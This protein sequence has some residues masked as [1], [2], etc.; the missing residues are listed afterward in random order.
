[1]AD[2][3]VFLMLAIIVVLSALYTRLRKKVGS[4]YLQQ[5]MKQLDDNSYKIISNF[6]LLEN[7]TKIDHVVV[8][9]YGVFIIMREN[10]NGSIYGN[11]T[12][13]EWI[14]QVKKKQ[15]RFSN[16]LLD[17]Q[18]RKADLVN[19]LQLNEKY[20]IPI[21]AFSNKAI[22]AIDPVLL[23]NKKVVHYDEL[24]ANIQLYKTP[25]LS[26]EKVAGIEGKLKALE[27][28]HSK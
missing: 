1:M 27:K 5:K 3:Y 6:Q 20:L 23:K 26:K 12:D 18:K 16:P 13:K 21:V 9:V 15:T 25:H 8:S 22:L 19:Y 10:F 4:S 28:A 14:F 2:L 24:V 7:N 11:E 17:N